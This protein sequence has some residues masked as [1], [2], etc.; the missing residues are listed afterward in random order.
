M[1]ICVGVHVHHVSQ[2]GVS[3][4]VGDSRH[5][6][7]LN[8]GPYHQEEFRAAS[9]DS[10]S[11]HLLNPRIGSSREPSAPPVHL[12]AVGLSYPPS[13]PPEDLIPPSQSSAS[14]IKAI[15]EELMRLSQ[16]QAVPLGFHS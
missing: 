5:P 9:R 14:L 12:D 10:V 11:T 8:L 7:A 4:R 6:V 2:A 16:K 13:A 3:A 15:R 1:F